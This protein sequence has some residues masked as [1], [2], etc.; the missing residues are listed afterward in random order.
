MLRSGTPYDA[1]L[2]RLESQSTILRDHVAIVITHG[3]IEGWTARDALAQQEQAQLVAVLSDLVDL[4]NG[5]PLPKY[6]EE[7][8]RAMDNAA[9]IIAALK[10]KQ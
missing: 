9:A 10:E 1:E 4:Q 3:R 7:W 2:L 8:H 6:A 5:P